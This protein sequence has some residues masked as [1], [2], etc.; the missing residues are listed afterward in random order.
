MELKGLHHLIDA[1][2]RIKESFPHVR[3][4]VVGDGPDRA[5]YQSLAEQKLGRTCTFLGAQPHQRVREEMQKAYVF[6]MPSIS[7]PNGEAESFGM[8]FLEAQACGVPVVAYAVGGI[9]EVVAHG[10]TGFLAEEGDVGALAG[11]LKT[12]LENP[13]LRHTMGRAGAVWVQTRFDRRRQNEALENLY[14]QVC[15]EGGSA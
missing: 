5:F 4:V 10:K 12:L 3:L 1:V 7:M 15:R 14:R 11:Y 2:S 8:V 13:D 9:P 6:S